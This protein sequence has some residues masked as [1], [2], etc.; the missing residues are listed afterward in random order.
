[1]FQ[2]PNLHF[3]DA[4]VNL[5]FILTY[6]IYFHMKCEGRNFQLAKDDTLH[7]V[8]RY[9]VIVTDRCNV[10]TFFTEGNT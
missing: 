4:V 5:N 1:M 7:T 3:S 8:R 2:A 9:F 6:N 10:K